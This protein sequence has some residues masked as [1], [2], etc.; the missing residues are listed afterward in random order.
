ML[1][2]VFYDFPDM[3]STQAGHPEFPHQNHI[4]SSS[5]FITIFNH[6][7]QWTEYWVTQGGKQ[8]PQC[9]SEAQMEQIYI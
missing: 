7:L 5:S 9:Y 3:R 2:T 4:S 6:K 1:H 8:T